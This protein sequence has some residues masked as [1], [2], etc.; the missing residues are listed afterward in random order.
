MTDTEPVTLRAQSRVG[1]LLKDKWRLDKLLG[2]GGMAAVYAATHRNSKRAA[3]KLL[4]PELSLDEGVRLRFL[5]EGYVANQ[6]GHE[7]AVAVDD[8]DVA[9][10]GSAFLVMELLDGETLEMRALRKGGRLEPAEALWLMGQV[11]DT[12]AAAHEKGIIHR[13][14]KPENLFLT[15]AGVVKVLDFGIARLRESAGDNS[16]TQTGLVMGTP[17]FMAPE[18]ARGRWDEVDARTDLWAM[19]ATLFTLLTGRF[20]HEAETVSEA[21][22]LAVTARAPLL[23]TVLPDVHPAVATLVDRALAYE[24][25]LRFQSAT[26]LR[27]ALRVAYATLA[28][29][30]LSE[31]L[32]VPEVLSDFA[33]ISSRPRSK[34]RFA[35]PTTVRGVSA[36][37][38]LDAGRSART[39][40]R[41]S[42][43]A[44]ALA[45]LS[46]VA[47]LALGS[48]FLLGK[49]PATANPD[50][51]P[52]L[53]AHAETL[54]PATSRTEQAPAV[55]AA[56]GAPAEKAASA[57]LPRAARAANEAPPPIA[58]STHRLL[59]GAGSGASK[60]ASP[61][62][63]SAT[64]TFTPFS[65]PRSAKNSGD[66]FAKRH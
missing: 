66:P 15:R 21:L 31:P 40:I 6:V 61:H 42:K 46:G 20:V 51:V 5:R 54:A 55:A 9:E 23:A 57:P 39:W 37:V 1:T 53:A 28:G 47:L 36:S 59:A 62:G 26:E 30:E 2:V 41:S 7:G 27:A 44:R 63:T 16:L 64:P 3:L 65:K 13:D 10:D 50:A 38:P 48:F 19:G 45:A 8:D 34:P 12:M 49:G 11:A 4:H 18:Q 24:R 60:R 33:V 43:T 35:A 25:E 52:R 32:S 56:T 58:L 29:T 17:S 14:L 22:A